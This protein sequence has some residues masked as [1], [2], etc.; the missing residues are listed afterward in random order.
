M[1]GLKEIFMELEEARKGE[2]V[3]LRMEARHGRS[4]RSA[5]ALDAFERKILRRIYGP[6]QEGGAGH[7]QC[8]DD[9]RMPKRMMEM[10]LQGNRPR[11]KPRA[12]WEDNV[13]VDARDLM[14]VTN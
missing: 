9:T 4:R 5:E 11:G 14:Q 12:R 13:A 2:K 8:L 7:V 10:N 6:I 1:V 3:W